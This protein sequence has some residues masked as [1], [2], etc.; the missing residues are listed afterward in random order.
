MFDCRPPDVAAL[1][2]A[3][4]AT[5][6]DL[7]DGLSGIFLSEGLDRVLGDL[8]VGLFCRARAS[9]LRLRARRSSNVG[10]GT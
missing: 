9:R 5:L 6:A 10:R 7:P 1:I 4:L 8:P 2:R 3:T